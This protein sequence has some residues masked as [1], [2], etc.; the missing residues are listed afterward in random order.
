MNKI[1]RNRGLD[2]PLGLQ[3]VEAPRIPIRSAQAGL[4]PEPQ[5]GW[6]GY[7]NEKIQM[8]PSGTEPAV[9]HLVAQSLKPPPPPRAP[10]D[11]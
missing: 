11:M 2:R 6:K 8:I 3:E 9:C 10:T 5:C 7:V 4:T 1:S